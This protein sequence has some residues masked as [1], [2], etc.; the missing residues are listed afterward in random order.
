MPFLFMPCKQRPADNWG[1]ACENLVLISR[2][3]MTVYEATQF[4]CVHGIMSLT[5]FHAHGVMLLMHFPVHGRM[6]LSRCALLRANNILL[7]AGKCINYIMPWTLPP[8]N[9]IMPCTQFV[10]D[11][12]CHIKSSRLDLIIN[13]LLITIS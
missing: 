13:A 4:C 6:A 11:G 10:L 3:Q 2:L 9:D 7:C 5:R 8:D 1:S 12:L